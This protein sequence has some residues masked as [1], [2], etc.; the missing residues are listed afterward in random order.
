MAELAQEEH[1]GKGNDAILHDKTKE[2]E[3]DRQAFAG[4]GSDHWA[5]GAEERE[6]AA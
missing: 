4:K 3:I 5:T 2:S 1:R 6:G